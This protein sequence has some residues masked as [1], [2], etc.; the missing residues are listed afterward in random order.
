M[1][2]LDEYS[3]REFH[4]HFG[5]CKQTVLCLFQLISGLSLNYSVGL[6]KILW[7]LYFLK[8]FSFSTIGFILMKV[9]NTMDVCAGTWQVS[10][11]TYRKWIWLVIDLL[12]KNLHTVSTQQ[13]FV[14]DF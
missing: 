5:V 13:I 11:R 10:S 14:I 9:Y 7:T 12:F 6:D 3:D 8:V 1:S 2:L 4:A